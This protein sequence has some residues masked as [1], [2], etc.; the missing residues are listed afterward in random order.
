MRDTSKK[1]LNYAFLLLK[2]RPRTT[3]EISVR[4]KN[5]KFPKVVIKKVIIYLKEYHYLDDREFARVYTKEKLR[6]G[7]GQRKISF[8][9]KKLGIPFDLIESSLDELKREIDCH[10]ILKELIDKLLL[11]YES[12]DRKKERIIR[13]LLNRGF[14]YDEILTF[15]E[16][17]N[18]K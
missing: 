6:H 7:F 15:M 2:Y 18:K 14:N 4:L 10:Q 3:K 17:E 1:A 5:K 8:A 13:Y 11:R 9:L 16:S 12:K